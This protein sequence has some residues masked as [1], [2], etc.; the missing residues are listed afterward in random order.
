MSNK[1]LT[2]KLLKYDY[3]KQRSLGE[4][5]DFFFLRFHPAA[6][7]LVWSFG[8]QEIVVCNKIISRGIFINPETGVTGPFL[9]HLDAS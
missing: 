3:Q 9:R 2:C 7:N 1:A 6:M 4:R 5:N 8:I